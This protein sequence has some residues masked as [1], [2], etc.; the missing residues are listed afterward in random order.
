MFFDTEQIRI[1]LGGFDT[2][3][4]NILLTHNPLYADSYS[5]WGA[6]LTPSWHIHG[7]MIRISFIGGLLSPEREFFPKYDTGKY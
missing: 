7:G 2:G 4:Y 5:N 6:D 3:P 1:I